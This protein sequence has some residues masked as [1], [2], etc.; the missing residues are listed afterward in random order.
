M[1]SVE[2]SNSK[3]FN[4]PPEKVCVSELWAALAVFIG[5]LIMNPTL[6]FSNHYFLGTIVGISSAILMS[7]RNI[8]SRPLVKQY[9]GEIIMLYQTLGA[10]ILLPLL[11]VFN[12]NLT[13]T[14]TINILFLAII[15]TAFAHTL[16]IRSLA[17][18]KATTTGTLS[19]LAPVIGSFLALIFLKEKL[20]IHTIIGG[21]IILCISFL[22]TK[23]QSKST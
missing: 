1:V 8:F 5:I 12:W 17:H 4:T 2:D 16:W 10:I 18:F 6:S 23:R 20:S 21:S 14:N 22:E 9:S 13:Q 11:F 19:C 3:G 7:I 15:C